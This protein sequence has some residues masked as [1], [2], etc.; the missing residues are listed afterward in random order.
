MKLKVKSTYRCRELYYI[1]GSTIEVTPKE[2]TAL[3]AD[4]PENFAVVKPRA[5]RAKK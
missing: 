2:A 5:N 4:A 1:G 3:M